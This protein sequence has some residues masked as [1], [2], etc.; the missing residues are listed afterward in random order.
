MENLKLIVER[1]M[2][3]YAGEG[4]N[5]YTYFTKSDNQ[6]IMSIVFVGQIDEQQFTT[7]SMM[8]RVVADRIIIEDDKTNK[9]LI[10]ALLQAGVPRDQ[11]VL[12]YAGEKT[13]E[14]A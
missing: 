4:L 11:I 3:E 5:G 12:A 1:E 6:T 9:P 8:V 13:E 2:R 7:T 10:D 14:T